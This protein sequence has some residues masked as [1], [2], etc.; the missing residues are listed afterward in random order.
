MP[1]PAISWCAVIAMDNI[2]KRDFRKG[3]LKEEKSGKSKEHNGTYIEFIPDPEIFKKCRYQKEYILKR[4][5]HYAYFNTGLTLYYNGEAI[6]SKNGLL[7][8]LNAEVTEDRSMSP[9]IIVA[10]SLNLPF[11]TPK[12]MEKAIFLLSTDNIPPMEEPI[13][14]PS[15]KAS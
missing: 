15:V 10:S 5:W 2:L 8:L 13:Y 3:L 7:D 14:Q 4:M 6:E 11:C 12:A 9:S 1:F